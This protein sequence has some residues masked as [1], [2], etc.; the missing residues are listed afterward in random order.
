MPHRLIVPVLTVTVVAALTLIGCNAPPPE[1]R[2]LFESAVGVINT[3]LI[4]PVEPPA[5]DSTISDEVRR[6]TEL[7]Q[8]QLQAQALE[9]ASEFPSIV[10]PQWLSAAIDSRSDG[11]RY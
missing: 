8:F 4:T 2:L 1:P 5:A 9:I 11:V 10:Q 7:A 3:V 6:S